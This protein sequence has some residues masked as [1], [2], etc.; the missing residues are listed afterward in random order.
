M[1]PTNAT[2]ELRKIFGIM[3]N[4]WFFFGLTLTE[5]APRV[6]NY[7]V[8]ALLVAELERE[9]ERAGGGVVAG[10]GAAANQLPHLIGA[11]LTNFIGS[12]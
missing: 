1:T 9:V 3:C 6:I 7:R 4:K 10:L 5:E 2:V 11:V 8:V 12:Y